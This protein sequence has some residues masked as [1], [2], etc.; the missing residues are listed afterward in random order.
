[1]K[2]TPIRRLRIVGFFEGISALLLFG[3]AMPLK[4][5]YDMPEAVRE[6]G[7]IHGI[8]FLLFIAALGLVVATRGLPRRLIIGSMIASVVPGGTFVLDHH[9]RKLEAEATESE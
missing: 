9:L 6:I 5:R 7:L 3:V 8:L 4:Y 2:N 1:M